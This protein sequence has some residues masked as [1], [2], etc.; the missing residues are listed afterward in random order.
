MYFQIRANSQKLYTSASGHVLAGENINQAFHREI[1][2]EIGV[3]EDI[4]NAK[5]VEVN[6]WKMDKIK[7]GVPLIDRAFANVYI[8]KID[9]YFVNFKFDENE[10]LGIVK[11]NAKECLD[12]LK[13][14]INKI[15]G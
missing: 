4:N 5:L 12:L 9:K 6:V 8:S 10:V 2:E 13:G 15:K 14:D 11:V 1:L 7:N 3:E